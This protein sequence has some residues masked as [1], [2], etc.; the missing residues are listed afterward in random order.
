MGGGRERIIQRQSI[1]SDTR[2]ETDRHVEKDQEHPMTSVPL[3]TTPHHLLSPSS[4][5]RFGGESALGVGDLDAEG[6]GLRD[7][8]DALGG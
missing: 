8:V 5:L 6:L 2:L 4:S 3:R 1:P 7:D